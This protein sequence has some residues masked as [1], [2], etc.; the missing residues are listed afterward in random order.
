MS[1]R[2]YENRYREFVN[3]LLFFEYLV[4]FCI[5]FG[6]YKTCN[7]QN[8]VDIKLNMRSIDLLKTSY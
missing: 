3:F 6:A 2:F 5:V 7:L 1:L 4:P 8:R